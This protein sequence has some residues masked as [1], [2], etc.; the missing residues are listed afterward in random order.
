MS[1]AGRST[2]LCSTGC[3]GARRITPATI[4]R[5]VTMALVA[6]LMVETISCSAE[7]GFVPAIS[8]AFIT[9]GIFILVTL[10]VR[11]VK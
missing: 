2:G 6:T 3:R 1:K 10:P 11:K 8:Q 4:T 7:P 9:Q 5:V